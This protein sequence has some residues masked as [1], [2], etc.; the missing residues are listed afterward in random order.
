[1]PNNVR[2][3][4]GLAFASW[5]LLA[6][7]AAHQARAENMMTTHSQPPGYPTFGAE[8][9]AET[10]DGFR[11]GVLSAQVHESIGLVGGLDLFLRQGFYFPDNQP[12]NVYLGGG[13]KWTIL[14]LNKK[15][16]IPGLALAGGGH[17]VVNG[18]WG[19]ADLTFLVDYRWGRWR[20]Y[21]SVDSELNFGRPGVE[22]RLGLI[23][24]TRFTIVNHVTWFIE[25]GGG[26]TTRGPS[27]YGFISSGPHIFI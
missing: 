11:T 13:V 19:G 22:F 6:V 5:S 21:I 27:G 15:E 9:Q 20:P 2:T 17:F 4:G 16:G 8:F 23:G 24:G 12:V 25:M 18:D 1:M 10:Q 3:V 7:L 14:S 26:F